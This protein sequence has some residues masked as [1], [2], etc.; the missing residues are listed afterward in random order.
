VRLG[1][2]QSLDLTISEALNQRSPDFPG[3]VICTA[4]DSLGTLLE[5]IKK[6]RVHRLVVVEGDVS[7]CFDH[8]FVMPI[9]TFQEEEKKGGKKGRLLGIITLSDVLRY[10][11]GEVGIGESVEEIAALSTASCTPLSPDIIS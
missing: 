4:G 9:V 5:L 2:Y 8:T 6:R 10:V 1:A 11:I 3:V 7:L